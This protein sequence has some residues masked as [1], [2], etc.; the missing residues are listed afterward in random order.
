MQSVQ[1]LHKVEAQGFRCSQEA[2]MVAEIR[3]GNGPGGLRYRQ[4][5]GQPAMPRQQ[6]RLL[7]LQGHAAVRVGIERLGN[8]RL[9]IFR[10]HAAKINRQLLDGIDTVFLEQI[11]AQAGER[12][13]R[14]IVPVAQFAQIVQHVEIGFYLPRDGQG[15]RGVVHGQRGQQQSTGQPQRRE[16]RQRRLLL[17][18]Q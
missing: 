3:C 13:V 9:G 1:A 12:R 8:A 5:R 7:P 4:H 17:F 11:P 14:G 2:L 15:A 18:R 10:H 16:Q 6:V